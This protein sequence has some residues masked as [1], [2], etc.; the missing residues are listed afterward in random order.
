MFVMANCSQLTRSNK[1]HEQGTV[2]LYSLQKGN[3][4]HEVLIMPS[5]LFILLYASTR[6]ACEIR[7]ILQ[8]TYAHFVHKCLMYVR[9]LLDVQ[10][11]YR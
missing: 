7:I 8:Q 5:V 4:R 3:G 10:R 1:S 11:G 9:C 2:N 6:Y